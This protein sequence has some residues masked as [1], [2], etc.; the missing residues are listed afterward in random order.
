MLC[1]S[2]TLVAAFFTLLSSLAAFSN[3]SNV[4]APANGVTTEEILFNTVV[5]F[6]VVP[7]GF[8]RR[9]SGVTATASS[10]FVPSALTLPAG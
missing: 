10:A 9:A 1:K 5:L 7:S 6:V 2:V 8:T 3:F 4:S